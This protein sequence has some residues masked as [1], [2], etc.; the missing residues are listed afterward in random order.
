MEFSKSNTGTT[1]KPA[2][3]LP[4]K[5]RGQRSHLA[6]KSITS[7]SGERISR[8]VDEFTTLYTNTEQVTQSGLD[9]TLVP[10]AKSYYGDDYDVVVICGRGSLYVEGVAV[11]LVMVVPIVIEDNH[12]I[13]T[14]RKMVQ[15][16]D[17]VFDKAR[18]RYD[19]MSRYDSSQEFYLPTEVLEGNLVANIEQAVKLTKDEKMVRLDG[20]MIPTYADLERE[21]ILQEF[22]GRG[23]DPI[24]DYWHKTTNDEVISVIEM[25]EKNEIKTNFFKHTKGGTDL[26]GVE[27]DDTFTI[28]VYTATKNTKSRDF[29]PN[30][31]GVTETLFEVSGVV[32]LV[33]GVIDVELD[34]RVKEVEKL[35]PLVIA[36]DVKTSYVLEDALLSIAAL[37]VI[38]TDN[39]WM[40]VLLDTTTE[41][42]DPG[43][44]LQAIGEPA[45]PFSKK[46]VSRA[47]KQEL[48]FKHTSEGAMVGLDIP[49]YSLMSGA[50]SVIQSAA[51][52][53]AKSLEEII[54][55]AALMCA[56]E[57]G[58]T[59]FDVNFPTG[60]ILESVELPNGYFINKED[61]TKHSSA[62]IDLDYICATHP[63]F[64]DLFIEAETSPDGMVDL[65]SI[66]ND[67]GLE[68]MRLTGIRRRVVFT[69]A[70]LDELTGALAE[71][72]FGL[73]MDP[74][75]SYKSVTRRGY[76]RSRTK[77]FTGS[78][79]SSSK[80]VRYNGGD[81]R[82]R[83]RSSRESFMHKRF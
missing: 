81:N 22:A 23:I 79:R 36:R 33:P 55:T 46:G 12:N 39:H 50:F 4:I 62:S 60:N 54:T 57:E 51:S 73:T 59:T 52:G 53:S 72:G 2:T 31:R 7:G 30:T 25:C 35:I 49:E 27:L 68:E 63:K 83:R 1:T 58:N 5:R 66:Y 16:L 65:I 26:L 47:A 82:T 18:G 78:G 42:R 45:K 17:I 61:G 43:L 64:I 75:Q 76:D 41:I 69:S 56:D 28:Q 71:C 37:S 10:M 48:L 38:A 19:R 3:G 34:G 15:D 9:I 11:P 14:P 8:I 20:I 74:S 21:E 77:K 32:S 13:L 29:G 70:F 44:T 40:D 80:I 24:L 6:T 67:I